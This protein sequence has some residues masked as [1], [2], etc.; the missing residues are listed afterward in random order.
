MTW[1]SPSW[2]LSTLWPLA[3]P[4]PSR[5]GRRTEKQ[6]QSLEG[7]DKGS[8]LGQQGR[9]KTINNSTD[10]R[11][12]QWV[13]T[14]NNLL[15]PRPTN[16]TLSLSQSHTEPAPAR[17]APFYGEHDVTWYGIAPGQLG[18]PVLALCEINSVLARTR[19]LSTPYSIPSTS[20]PDYFTDLIPLTLRAIALKCLSSSFSP[21]LLG[22][23][24]HY[25]L[26]EQ[27]Q[28]CVLLDCCTLHP[29]FSRPV[30]LVWSMITVWMS[31]M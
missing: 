6:Q 26:S 7:W 21:W 27:E 25:S 29:E 24:C 11:Y 28:W 13:I 3:H 8:L 5:M 18:S 23:I 31:K 4:S 22:S 16:R 20:C 30:Y 9:G 1:F 15:I 2:Q 17:L 12:S 19:T 10:N 14:E